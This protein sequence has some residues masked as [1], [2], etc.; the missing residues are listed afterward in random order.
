MC[1]SPLEQRH[2]HV[3]DIEQATLACTCR[4]CYLLFT[5]KGSDGDRF[6]A[7]PDRVLHDPDRPITIADWESL[8]APVS[9]AFFFESSALGMV[10]AS[11]PS[12][13]G[14]AAFDLDASRRTELRQRYP[15]LDAAEPDLEGIFVQSMGERIDVFLIPIDLRYAFLGEMRMAWQGLDGGDDVRTSTAK[16]VADLRERSRSLSG[17]RPKSP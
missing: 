13:A 17:P 5:A 11:Y 1:S 6:Q 3:V 10:V 4:A 14:P 15:L 9:S 12:P 7:V 2:G 16:F 8:R